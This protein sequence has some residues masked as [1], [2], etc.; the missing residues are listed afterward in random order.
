MGMI[1][2]LERQKTFF[3]SG[4]TR[5]LSFRKSRLKKLRELIL[6]REHDIYQALAADLGKGTMESFYSEVAYCLNEIDHILRNLDRWA[7]PR[8]TAVPLAYQPASAAVVPEPRGVVLIVSPWNY[9]FQ[10]VISPLIAAVAAGNCAI[11]KP[12]SL[13]EKTSALLEEMIRE[14]FVP[15]HVS[16]VKIPSKEMGSLLEQKFDLIF[17][18]GSTRVG[19]IVMEA[20][21]KNLT[22]VILELG[23]KSPCIVDPSADLEVSA[24]RIVWGKFMNAGQ[25]CVAPDYVLAHSSIKDDLVKEMKGQILAFYGKDPRLSIDYSRIVSEKHFRRLLSLM[26]G[27]IV[28]GGENIKEDLYI[29]PTII[30]NVAWDSRIMEDEIFGPILPVLSYENLDE[31]IEKINERPKPLALYVFSEYHYVAEK[32]LRNIPSGG[33]CVNHT[34]L[35][36]VPNGLPFGGVGESGMGSY[37]GKASFDAFS[38]LRSILRKPFRW[39]SRQLYPPYGRYSSFWR[40]LMRFFS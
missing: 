33:A 30:D 18:T 3:S 21:A 35:H 16:L 29:A 8:K 38:H 20:A 40:K 27:D 9:P 37:H 14:V 24:R 23:G 25:T 15:E 36:L 11:I 26:K 32:I 28:A 19:K 5:S 22:P 34:L 39:D 2:V 4:E 17:Y 7:R 12:S 6:S 31:I 1:D 10:L 13:A